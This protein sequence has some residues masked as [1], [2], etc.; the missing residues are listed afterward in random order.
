VTPE[1]L[2]DMMRHCGNEIGEGPF[3]QSSE[4]MISDERIHRKAA[5][6]T[7]FGIL[8]GIERKLRGL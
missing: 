6:R 3:E 2:Q 5:R 7:L 4:R 1:G 8:D